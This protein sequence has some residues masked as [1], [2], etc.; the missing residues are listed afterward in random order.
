M[1]SV[2]LC[3]AQ[4]RIIFRRPVFNMEEIVDPQQVLVGVRF[5]IFCC[6]AL[7]L[8]SIEKLNSNQNE[9]D[10]HLLQIMEK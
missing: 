6:K 9:K 7:C 2:G 4:E 8:V 5:H 3:R 10:I 1:D